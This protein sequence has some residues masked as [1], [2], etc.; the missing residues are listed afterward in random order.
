MNFQDRYQ[1]NFQTDYLG[2]GAFADVFKA[3][4][5]LLDRTVALKF[6]KGTGSQYDVL[7]EIKT[8]IKQD[9]SHPNLIRYYDAA[10][11]EMTDRF[12]RTT[13]DQVGIIEYANGK[14]FLKKEGI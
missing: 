14:E 3:H 13:Q 8:V 1:Y 2:G 7:N 11:V 4:D 6:Y 10:L 9:L 5:T 12:G